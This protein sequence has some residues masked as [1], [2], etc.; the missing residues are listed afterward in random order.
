MILVNAVLIRL[1]S[2]EESREGKDKSESSSF[3]R[4]PSPEKG[5]E[6]SRI[7]VINCISDSCTTPR[8]Y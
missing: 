8:H 1:L 7:E 5:I 3:L 2:T 6:F 4:K